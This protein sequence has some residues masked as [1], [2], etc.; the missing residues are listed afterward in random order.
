MIE[1]SGS[2][3][4]ARRPEGKSPLQD[5]LRCKPLRVLGGVLGAVFSGVVG[6]LSHWNHSSS[7]PGAAGSSPIRPARTIQIL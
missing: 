5:H 4:T 7:S 6:D 3:A 2:L 1:P